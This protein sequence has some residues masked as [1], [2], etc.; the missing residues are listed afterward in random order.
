LDE[1]KPFLDYKSR[2]LMFRE[3]VLSFL[4]VSDSNPVE[5]KFCTACKA[6]KMDKDCKSCSKEFSVSSKDNELAQ[7][8]SGNA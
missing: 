2:D 5:D 4:G 6:A 8:V 1:C 3:A 7:K